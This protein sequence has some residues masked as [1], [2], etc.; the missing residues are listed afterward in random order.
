MITKAGRRLVLLMTV[1]LLVVATGLPALST[2][3]TADRKTRDKQFRVKY[4]A[5]TAAIKKGARVRVRFEPKSI[6]CEAKK[7]LTFSI[8]AA[9]V[10]EVGYDSMPWSRSK[11]VLREGLSVSPSGMGYGVPLYLLGVL[12]VT[13]AV[14]PFGGKDHFVHIAWEWN[15]GDEAVWFEVSKG[16]Y[17]ALLAE[18]E[19]ATGKKPLD[20]AKEREEEQRELQDNAETVEIELDR[21]VWVAG[22]FLKPGRYQLVLLERT[23]TIGELYFFRGK[24]DKR[25]H[26]ETGAVVEIVREASKISSPK[27]IFDRPLKLAPTVVEIQLPTKSL[28]IQ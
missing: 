21:R 2:P 19:R 25:K 12:A 5:G 26:P 8:P 20:L 10:T 28:R 13:G 24:K 22:E 6:I 23:E 16:R 15:D 11:A 27:L 18:L 9:G 3:S 14:S 1:L 4:E 17:A 7:G